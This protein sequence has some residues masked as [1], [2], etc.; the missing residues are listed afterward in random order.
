MYAAPIAPPKRPEA[1]TM[2]NRRVLG[3]ANR[4]VMALRTMWSERGRGVGPEP[5]DDG[6]E[7]TAHIVER[8][9]GK[10]EIRSCRS[11]IHSCILIVTR[12]SAARGGTDA[13]ANST[14]TVAAVVGG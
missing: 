12:Y 9:D 14:A 5:G 6:T 13:G 8:H 3:F 2:P 7:D 10:T 4:G 1:M 11:R